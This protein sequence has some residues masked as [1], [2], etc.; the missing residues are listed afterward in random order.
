M[1]RMFASEKGLDQ[2][3][4]KGLTPSTQNKYLLRSLQFLQ[5]TAQYTARFNS[6]DL[7]IVSLYVGG[8]SVS[9]AISQGSSI[10][11]GDI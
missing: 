7:D 3:I 4:F 6:F 5:Y 8:E 2:D 9:V 11:S 10:D 1:L